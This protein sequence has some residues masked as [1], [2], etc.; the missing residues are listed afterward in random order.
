M[1]RLNVLEEDL[2]MLPC[3]CCERQNVIEVVI[4][5]WFKFILIM[6][7][8]VLWLRMFFLLNMY[9]QIL[10]QVQS[11][12][13]NFAYLSRQIIRKNIK[14]GNLSLNLFWRVYNQQIDH[15]RL[16]EK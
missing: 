15:P 1:D 5:I 2:S 13:V 10:K 14:M 6:S 8:G 4:Q 11:P 12:F 7:Y 3:N 16:Q 9:F